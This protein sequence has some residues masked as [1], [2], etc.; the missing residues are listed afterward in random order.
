MKKILKNILRIF[1]YDIISFNTGID[2]YFDIQKRIESIE[3]IILDVGANQ[4]QTIQKV[5]DLFPSAVIH[6][7]EPSP[8]TFVKLEKNTFKFSNVKCWNLGMGSSNT[9]LLLNENEF[10]DMSSFLTLGDKGWGKVERQI[11]VDVI[12]LD[13]FLSR[14][15]INLIDLLKIDTQGFELEVLKGGLN[16]FYLNKVRLIFFEV[17]FSAIYESLPSFTELFNFCI[18]NGFELVAIY[19]CQYRDG[20]AAW[21]DVLFINREIK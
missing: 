12:T 8:S 1:G 19:P 11:H 15:E 10:D 7:F 4:G 3:P 21:T 14:N 17:N 18:S 20:K 13:S 16:S 6:A 5:K 2:P 9:K